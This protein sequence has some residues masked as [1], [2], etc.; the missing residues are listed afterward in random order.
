ML[1]SVINPNL[2]RWLKDIVR[3]AMDLPR[4]SNGLDYI[5]VKSQVKRL[6]FRKRMRSTRLSN[7]SAYSALTDF[8]VHAGVC[9]PWRAGRHLLSGSP[10]A[11]D[12]ELLEC[13]N[14]IE[15]ESGHAALEMAQRLDRLRAQLQET[16]IA[17]DANR[18]AQQGYYLALN[19]EYECM[20]L[21]TKYPR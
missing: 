5:Q 10:S 7:K 8:L 12:D 18:E 11:T 2:P 19:L 6:E 9:D 3:K 17:I 13:L 21:K 14:H 20:Q 16:R 1:P 4:V 15:F